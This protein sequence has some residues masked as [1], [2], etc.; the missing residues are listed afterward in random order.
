[1]LNFR[2]HTFPVLETERLFLRK[3]NNSDAPRIMLIRS[4]EVVNKFLDRPPSIDRNGALDFISKIEKS[5]DNRESFY[6]GITLKENQILT[7][8]VCFFNIEPELARAEVGF[9]L[10]PDFHGK[11]IMQEALSI[12]LNFVFE[13][14]KLKLILAFVKPGNLSSIKILQRNNF[15]LDENYTY[16]SKE[17]SGNYLIYY[18]DSKRQ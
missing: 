10:H 15:L 12:V 13:E 6:W 2:F 3:L 16:V 14:I 9:E 8:S 4:N 5:I 7:G 18:L 17:S 11:G 1:M